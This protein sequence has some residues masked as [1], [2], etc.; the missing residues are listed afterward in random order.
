MNHHT[1]EF[2]LNEMMNSLVSINSLLITAHKRSLG[3]GNVFTPVCDSVHKV[4]VSAYCMLGIR[5]PYPDTQPFPG[6][7]HTP[8][9]HTPGHPHRVDTPP[10][11]TPPPGIPRDTVNIGMHTCCKL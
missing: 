10:R 6:H 7:I 2:S 9:T 5:T 1:M 3:Q 4:G 8:W 11:Q